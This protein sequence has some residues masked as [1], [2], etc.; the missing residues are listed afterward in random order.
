MKNAQLKEVERTIT[1]RRFLGKTDNFADKQERNFNKKMLK[2]YLR[3]DANFSFGLDS[4]TRQP[5]M[6][7]VLQETY[8]VKSVS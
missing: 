3:G 2:A 6:F 1:K 8:E 4:E 5:I 7:K